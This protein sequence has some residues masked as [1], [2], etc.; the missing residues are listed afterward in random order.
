MERSIFTNL[1]HLR[2]LPGRKRKTMLP[3]L[4][5]YRFSFTSRKVRHVWI[6]FY[7]SMEVALSDSKQVALRDNP[8]ARDFM[9]ESDQDDETIRKSWGLDF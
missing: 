4:K 8:D 3:E 7:H 5:P 1:P 9:I 6:R 2:R